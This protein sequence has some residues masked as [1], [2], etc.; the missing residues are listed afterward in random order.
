MKGTEK[1]TPDHIEVLLK[2]AD[3]E[4]YTKEDQWSYQEWEEGDSDTT[5][6]LHQEHFVEVGCGLG[7]LWLSHPG[8][9]VSRR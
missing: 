1:K 9:F 6:S 7:Q 8:R 4:G 5:E 3:T 2:P